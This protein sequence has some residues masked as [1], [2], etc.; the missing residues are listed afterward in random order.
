LSAANVSLGQWNARI[1]RR[2][3]AACNPGHPVDG[4]ARFVRRALPAGG[5]GVRLSGG[6]D[7]ARLVRE[8]VRARVLELGVELASGQRLKAR[9]EPVEHKQPL[10]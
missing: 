8:R 2:S 7:R 3:S 5:R 4:S 9:V 1:R 6:E 10:R